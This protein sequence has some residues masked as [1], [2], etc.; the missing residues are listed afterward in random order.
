MC[1]LPHNI[2]LSKII[3]EDNNFNRS[4]IGKKEYFNLMI[5]NYFQNIF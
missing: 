3:F 2:P 1:K 4:K 5:R